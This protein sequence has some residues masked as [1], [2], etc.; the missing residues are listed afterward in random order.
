M[1]RLLQVALHSL[2]LALGILAYEDK[3]GP[4]DAFHV[5]FEFTKAAYPEVADRR[6]LIAWFETPKISVLEYESRGA[7]RGLMFS[8]FI[9]D[10]KAVANEHRGH[11][12]TSAPIEHRA[13]FSGAFRTSTNGTIESF[14]LGV[15]RL[16]DLE[17]LEQIRRRIDATVQEGSRSSI[18]NVL[19]QA[20]AQFPPSRRS[21][22]ESRARDVI[23]RMRK[24][25]GH[26]D[27]IAVE[28]ADERRSEPVPLEASI[29]VFWVV[30]GVS[31]D[32]GVVLVLEPL[33]GRLVSFNRTTRTQ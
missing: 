19:K 3:I 14:Q 18:E 9:D 27:N 32:S 25:I 4:Q 23:R 12:P 13:L 24:S 21:A 28:F 17:K 7:P 33:A 5:A 22:L 8:L 6:D 1:P 15:G 20:S 31:A 30:R 26:I 11:P 16:V 29:S 10:M 2:S